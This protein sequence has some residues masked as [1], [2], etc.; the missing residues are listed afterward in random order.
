MS[1]AEEQTDADGPDPLIGATIGNYRILRALGRGGMGAVYLGEHPIIRSQVAIKFLHPKYA[2]DRRVIDRFF[3][4]AR[5]VNLI[6]HPNILKV[7]DLSMTADKRHY[8]VMEF[9]N[10]APLGKLIGSAGL[11]LSVAGPILLQCCSALQAAHEA[12]I[13]HRDLKPDNIYLVSHLGRRN[14]V[15][16]VDFGIAKLIDVGETGRTQTGAVIGTPAYMSP[17]Q[18]TGENERIDA[19]SDVYALG[20][21]M[22]QMFTGRLPFE[23]DTFGKL[24]IAQVQKQP[25]SPRSIKAGLPADLEKVILRALAKDPLE[26][27]QS[28]MELHDEI[29][30]CM[31]RAGLSAELPVDDGAIPDGAG[32]ARTPSEPGRRKTPMFLSAPSPTPRASRAPTPAASP[33]AAPKKKSKTLLAGGAAM[34]A[35]LLIGGGLFAAGAFDREPAPRPRPRPV[36]V[37]TPV[38]EPAPAPEPAP[39]VPA[40]APEP[41]APPPVEKVRTVSITAAS[42]PAGATVTARWDGGEKHGRTPLRFAVPKGAH[43]TLDYS[44]K[45]YS[46]SQEEVTADEPRTVNADLVQ[47]L[48]D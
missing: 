41:P 13:V 17:E 36:A 14:F 46:P 21:V 43:V 30:A 4:E 48:G 47:L 2:S 27:Q 24:L 3:N 39:V 38:P 45:G 8:F 40:K 32:T 42:D 34:A 44:M 29:H 26:R 18:A 33:K 1:D 12:G 37:A 6:G 28:M 5:A 15:K 25:P 9:L 10:G 7:L 23:E 31:Q 20:G 22:F 19:R 16:I 35:A 11:P